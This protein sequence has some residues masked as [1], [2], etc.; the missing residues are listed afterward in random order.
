MDFFTPEF[1]DLLVIVNIVVGVIIAGRRFL[2]DIRGPLP[3][4]APDWA[5][6]AYHTDATGR[7]SSH[8]S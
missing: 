3:D 8:S 7:S 5:R 6:A 4:D 2:K 1:F